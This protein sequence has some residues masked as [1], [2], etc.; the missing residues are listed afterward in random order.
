MALVHRLQLALQLVD[1][2]PDPLDG[3]RVKR[4][5]DEDPVVVDLLAKFFAP[6]THGS[7][8]G[9]GREHETLSV[10]DGCRGTSDDDINDGR[11]VR[12]RTLNPLFAPAALLA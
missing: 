1:Q 12:F 2:T 11:Y 8:L 4:L 5:T 6:L 7:P 10:I 3:Q 9:T